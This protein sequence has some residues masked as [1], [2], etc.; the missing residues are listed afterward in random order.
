M[1]RP[2]VDDLAQVGF[3]LACDEVR[4]ITGAPE[5]ITMNDLTA[6]QMVALLT[7]LRPAWERRQARQRKPAAVLAICSRSKREQG[8]ARRAIVGHMGTLFGCC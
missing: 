5:H 8:A 2:S 6:C 1:T 7:V 3:E 4:E